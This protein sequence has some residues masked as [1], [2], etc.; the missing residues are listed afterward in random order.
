MKRY[1]VIFLTFWMLF[2]SM[3]VFA[4]EKS[5]VIIRFAHGFSPQ[6]LT[7]R[8]LDEWA[9]LVE[10]KSGGAAKVQIFPA[11]QLY[12]MQS[13][14]QAISNRNI[15]AGASMTPYAT[16]IIP[17]VGIWALPS[18]IRNDNDA[19]K[20]AASPV[21]TKLDLMFEAKN[22]H[23]VSWWPF[24]GIKWFGNK[25]LITPA[26]VKGLKVR[27]SADVISRVIE[28]MGGTPVFIEANEVYGAL[29]RGMIDAN[30]ISAS[31]IIDRKLIEVTKYGNDISAGYA[32]L[33][34][35]FNKAV[36][37][38]YPLTLRSVI[39]EASDQIRKKVELGVISDEDTKIKQSI[40]KGL[41]YHMTT[42]EEQGLWRKAAQPV[43]EDFRRI[44]GKVGADLLS[45]V[46]DVTSQKP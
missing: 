13:L 18:L 17:A 15:D 11:G 43:W 37:E 14:P 44:N 23:I 32:M 21:A 16:Q 12:D 20:V 39:S 24:G 40:S 27:S 8:S 3:V 36:W 31:S 2:Q 7:G 41:K 9:K 46:L 34:L 38:S 42:P 25:P 6:S 29:Q 1:T 26:D 10:V 45:T 33:M 4:Q 28:Q 19:F 30:T 22:L 35:T 5:Q